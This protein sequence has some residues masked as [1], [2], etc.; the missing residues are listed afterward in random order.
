MG[1]EIACWPSCRNIEKPFVLGQGM[2]DQAASQAVVGNHI[3]TRTKA[4]PGVATVLHG[5]PT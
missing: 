3:F 5:I 4:K 1:T 2:G